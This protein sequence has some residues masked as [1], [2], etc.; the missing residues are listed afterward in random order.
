MLFSL[1]DNPDDKKPGGDDLLEH[2]VDIEDEEEVRAS[3]S[4]TFTHHIFHI[5]YN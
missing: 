3:V 1:S 4:I 2:H 5:A